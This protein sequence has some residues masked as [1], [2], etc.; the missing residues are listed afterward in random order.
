[1]TNTF[2][3]ISLDAKEVVQ[4]EFE[5]E[6]CLQGNFLKGGYLYKFLRLGMTN[7]LWQGWKD[8]LYYPGRLGGI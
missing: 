2:T 1:M 3:F 5:A 6:H 4:P 7:L 8:H